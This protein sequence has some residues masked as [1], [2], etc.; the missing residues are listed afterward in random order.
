MKLAS[1]RNPA[2]ILGF[3]VSVDASAKGLAERQLVQIQ[4]FDIIY[5]ISEWLAE[6]V[7]KRTPKVFI[8]ETTATI[9]VLKIFSSMKDKHI[10]GGR[11]EKGTVFVGEDAKIIRKETEIGRGKIRNLQQGKND[12]GEVREGVEF[13]CQFQSDIT[14]APGDKLEVFK[15]ME[16]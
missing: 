10:I 3:D 14:P 6:V 15:T 8:D 9:K 12:T 16:K 11:V 7:Q 4:T 1:G 5:K 2:I 13:G